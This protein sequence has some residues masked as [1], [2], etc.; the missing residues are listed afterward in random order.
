MFQG[1]AGSGNDKK[2]IIWS[3]IIVPPVSLKYLNLKHSATIQNGCEYCHKILTLVLIP[4]QFSFVH[5]QLKP[6]QD[7]SHT[8]SF[9]N[10]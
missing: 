7:S 5:I 6:V 2:V 4:S 3:D 10:I 8:H 1:Y 9:C